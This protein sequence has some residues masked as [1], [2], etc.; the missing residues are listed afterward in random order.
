M[1]EDAGLTPHQGHRV[2]ITLL[3]VRLSLQASA[4]QGYHLCVCVILV[5]RHLAEIP[6]T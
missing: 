1:Q 4:P 6:W 2:G 3:C 5:Y